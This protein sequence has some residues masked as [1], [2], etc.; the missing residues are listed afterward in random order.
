LSGLAD[1]IFPV[2]EDPDLKCKRKSKRKKYLMD[3]PS[4][5]SVLIYLPLLIS[6][7]FSRNIQI[8]FMG[9]GGLQIWVLSINFPISNNSWP[10]TEYQYLENLGV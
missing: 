8:K 2:N 3:W 10:L 4:I 6:T 1:K 7:I 5:S 9:L